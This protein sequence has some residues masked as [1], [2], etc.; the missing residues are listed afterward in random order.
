MAPISLITILILFAF[1]LIF[2]MMAIK[3]KASLFTDIAGMTTMLGLAYTLAA[4]SISIGGGF[5]GTT[6]TFF[7]QLA[8][9]SEYQV[10]VVLLVI[11]TTTS[12]VLTMGMVRGK[13]KADW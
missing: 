11:F 2:D 4:G 7:N 10:F 5:D 8:S 9:A 6:D 1:N 12:F 3:W 13:K